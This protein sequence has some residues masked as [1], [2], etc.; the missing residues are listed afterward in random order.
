LIA[1]FVAESDSWPKHFPKLASI[2]IERQ[3]KRY[4]AKT[5]LQNKNKR[6]ELWLEKK[7]GVIKLLLVVLLLRTMIATRRTR[8]ELVLD[9][10][11]NFCHK[12]RTIAINGQN[13]R[14]KEDAETASSSLFKKSRRNKRTARTT[15]SKRLVKRSKI[16]PCPKRPRHNKSLPQSPN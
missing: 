16:S 4:D 11:T 7:Q 1:L 8:N 5:V 9:R 3:A 12:T 15:K 2:N 10:V 13:P 14:A 6:K